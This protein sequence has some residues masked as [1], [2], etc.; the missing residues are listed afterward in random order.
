M[1]RPKTLYSLL[2]I[3]KKTGISYPTLVKY[4]RDFADQIPA[5]GTGRNRRYTVDSVKVFQ[6]LFAKSRPG[7]KP[8]ADWVKHPPGSVATL[9]G[10][11]AHSAPGPLQLAE[12]DRELLRNVL[13]ALREVADKLQVFSEA[14]ARSRG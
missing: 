7:R 5:V 4:A 12:E 1:A 9:P 2:D 14:T 13:E 10:G 3:K 8:G 6:R 11:M